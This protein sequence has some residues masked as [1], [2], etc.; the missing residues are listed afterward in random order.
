MRL[1]IPDESLRIA[2]KS[3]IGRYT[4]ELIDGL[5]RHADVADLQT[6]RRGSVGYEPVQAVG[7]ASTAAQAPLSIRLRQRVLERSKLAYRIHGLLRKRHYARLLAAYGG[8]IYHEPNFILRPFEGH[9]IATVH[10][11]SIMHYPEYHPKLRVRFIM[12]NIETTLREADRVIVDSNVVRSELIKIFGLPEDKL[13]TVP[14]GVDADFQPRPAAA[15]QDSLKRYA[16]D[17][18]Q[19][20]FVVGTIEPRKN[21]QRVFA[22]YS[23]LPERVQDRMPL[24]LTGQRGWDDSLLEQLDGLIARGRIRFLGYL[25]E[26]ALQEL[27]SAAGLVLFLSEYEGFGLPVLESLASATPIITSKGTAMEEIAGSLA[28]LV[29]PYDIDG[30]KAAILEI[31]DRQTYYTGDEFRDLARRHVA[32]FRWE[33]LIENMVAVYRS[34]PTA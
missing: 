6:F 24:V 17:Y 11:L 12:D 4:M 25:P 18:K 8:Y 1:L 10:D 23:R 28:V 9:K 32:D 16:L 31:L 29:D 34:V 30:I 15:L 13:E 19:F 5:H 27:Y 21:L 2:P 7:Q 22:A 20:I 33:N 14:L 26:T 3:G